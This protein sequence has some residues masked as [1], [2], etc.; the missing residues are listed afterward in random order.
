MLKITDGTVISCILIIIYTQLD[1]TNTYLHN[2]IC[3]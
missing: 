3:Y 2:R 1:K